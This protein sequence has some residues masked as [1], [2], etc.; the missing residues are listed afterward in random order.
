ML[1]RI[2]D[3]ILEFK[4]VD[5]GTQ[6]ARVAEGHVCFAT[7]VILTGPESL[8]V[9]V[10]ATFRAEYHDWQD[11]P[12]PDE[13]RPIRVRISEAEMLV[14]PVGGVAEFD[15]VTDYVPEGGTLTVEAVGES[16]GCDSGMLEVDVVE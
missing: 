11:N 2:G 8:T 4:N 5:T 13:D 15:I 3:E 7:K 10:P 14:E 12:L 1:E 16:F 9:G 6:I